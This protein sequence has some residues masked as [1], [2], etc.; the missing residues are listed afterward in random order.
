M[1]QLFLSKFE[2][3]ASQLFSLWQNTLENQLKGGKVYLLSDVSDYGWLCVELWGVVGQKDHGSRVWWWKAVLL[4]QE[5]KRMNS[6]DK[7]KARYNK[8]KTRYTCRGHAS[9]EWLTSS[10]QA[11]L[12]IVSTI[13]L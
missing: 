8:E 3:C 1:P 11:P 13:S 4:W 5:R 6:G 2:R 10:N 9:S 7:D 12:P